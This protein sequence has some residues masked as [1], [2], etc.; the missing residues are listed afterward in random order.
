MHSLPLYPATSRLFLQLWGA[1]YVPMHLCFPVFL[2]SHM[3]WS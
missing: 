3:W 2:S 1:S